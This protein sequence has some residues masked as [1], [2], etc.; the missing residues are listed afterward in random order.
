MLD[1]PVTLTL[2]NT[3]SWTITVD[4]AFAGKLRH[5]LCLTQSGGD[6]MCGH[7]GQIITVTVPLHGAQVPAMSGATPISEM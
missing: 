3:H 4:P 7:S 5:L 6:A 1:C 2:S